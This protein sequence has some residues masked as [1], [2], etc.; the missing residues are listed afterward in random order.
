MTEHQEPE[1]ITLW[2]RIIAERDRLAA[3]VRSWEEFFASQ[4]NGWQP[5]EEYPEEQR[6]HIATMRAHSESL[7]IPL[8]NS[9]QKLDREINRGAR[10]SANDRGH[11]IEQLA[12]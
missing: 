5:L 7:I 6:E 9:L 11:T 1:L 4:R 3:N 8:R 2:R 10:E 12:R